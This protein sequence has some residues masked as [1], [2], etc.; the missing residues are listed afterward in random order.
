MKEIYKNGKLLKTGYTTGSC[1]AAASGAAAIMLLTKEEIEKIQIIIPTN[2]K[3]VLQVN[4]INLKEEFCSCSITKDGG[5]DPD[6]TTG[7]EIFS[8]VELIEEGIVILGGKGIGVATVEGLRV[9]KGEPAINPIPRKNI[10]DN[11]NRIKEEYNY[12]GGFKVEIFA[13]EGEERALKTYN[14]RLG[15]EGGISILGTT[16]IVQPMS[17][18][19]IV[20]TIKLE[21]DKWIE[22]DKENILISPGNYGGSYLKNQMNI[23]LDKGVKISNYLGETLDYLSYKGLENILLVG[24][25]GKIVKV[26]GGIMNTHSSY[27]DGRMEILASHTAMLVEDKSLIKAIMNSKTTDR[28]LELLEEKGLL[29]SVMQSIIHKIVYHLKFR[30]KVAKNI[31]VIIFGLGERE[32]GRTDKALELAKKFMEDNYGR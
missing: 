30:N 28:A 16:G 1:S 13:P 19:A 23:D 29:N 9:A 10:I 31:E 14:Q 26:A 5:D 22:I 6:V 21:I 32:I 27:G 12:S 7:M 11:L 18:S 25:I 20:E 4:N 24:H 3:I 2:E 8:K 15:I 17:E